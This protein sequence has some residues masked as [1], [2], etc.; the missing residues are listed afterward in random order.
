[1][2]AAE[3]LHFDIELY[4]KVR[5]R[6]LPF[7]FLLYVV[8]YIDRINVGF[9]ALQMNRELGFSEAVF[10]LGAGI[11]FIGYF[12][13]E[14]P[15]N[16]IL[17]RL[18]ARVWISRIMISWGMVAIAMMFTRGARSFYLLR[19]LLGTAEAGFFPGIIF[20]LTHWFPARERARAVS[21]FMTATQ[22]AGVIGGPLSGVLL[23]MNGVWHLAGWQ[24]LFLAEGIPAVALGIAAAKYLPDSPDQASWLKSTE[25]I[26]LSARL[27]LERESRR[28]DD[29]LR[30]AITNSQVWLLAL[31][32]FTIVFGHY[33]IAFWLPQILKG[34]G[35]L[36]DVHVGLLS[37]LPFLTA[38]VVM[39]IVAKQSDSTNERR[40]HLALSAFGGAI[41][42]A[43]S[44]ASHSPWI[45]LVTISIA[46]AGVSSTA[47]PF[48]TL[49]PEILDGPAA[50]GGIALINS[51]GNLAGFVGPSIVGLIRQMTGGF[52][53]GL[54]IMAATV[55]MASVIALAMP[56]F[57][58]RQPDRRNLPEAL[59]ES[60]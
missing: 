9:A 13:L 8:A 52:G 56:E 41:A 34:L 31:L 18:G 46:A 16:L 50:A 55:M 59:G 54:L 37:S 47:G 23:A 22:I 39:V 44:A 24:W 21:L 11:F 10:G 12:V 5:R 36:S 58:A 57:E 7:L 6:L 20:Y 19:F 42:L 43:A 45:S 38:A 51:T 17:Q 49:P 1:M 25:R 3:D 15:S 26:R 28:P 32:Y 2:S 27:T 30:A 60:R 40:W 29:T 4:A 33:G 35:G 48:W 14:I 53:G